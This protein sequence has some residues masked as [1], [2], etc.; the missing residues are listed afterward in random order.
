MS[1]SPTHTPRRRPP[2]STTAATRTTTINPLASLAR[3]LRAAGTHPTTSNAHRLVIAL[4]RAIARQLAALTRAIPPAATRFWARL[5]AHPI[6][7]SLATRANVPAPL[8]AAVLAAVAL[9]LTASR[10]AQ[11]AAVLVRAVPA[12]AA[13]CA[14]ESSATQPETVTL[15]KQLL[16]TLALLSAAPRATHPLMAVGIAYVALARQREAADWVYDAIV[17]P[18]AVAVAHYVPGGAGM[19]TAV[20]RAAWPAAAVPPP[21]VE[22][23]RWVV[24]V[25]REANRVETT[26]RATLD[27]IVVAPPTDVDTTITGEAIA[28]PRVVVRSASIETT[29]PMPT[30]MAAPVVRVALADQARP[31][32][33][34]GTDPATTNHDSENDDDDATPLAPHLT[35]ALPAS[36]KASPVWPATASARLAA[37]GPGRRPRSASAVTGSRVRTANGPRVVRGRAGSSA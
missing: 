9:I 16:L 23:A 3:A 35:T 5:V 32:A 12:H 8:V 18:A 7:T 19:P 28:P 30:P 17:R 29:E 34:A 24:R 14:I 27:H 22:V 15:A 26:A 21:V 36:G 2:R 1:A 6:I 33:S 11:V 25:V 31:T 13:V 20:K 10:P 4:L 37:A